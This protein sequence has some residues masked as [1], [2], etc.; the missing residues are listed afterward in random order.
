MIRNLSIVLFMALG[1]C[2][3]SPAPRTRPLDMSAQAHL[4]E[5][6][7]HQQRAE[8]L[9][10]IEARET[11]EGNTEWQYTS[12]A[13]RDVAGQHGRAARSVDPNAPRCP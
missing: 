7:K 11:T 10:R 3:S 1:A 6:W 4:Q 5:C 9:Q 2:V 12:T 8:E 13:E